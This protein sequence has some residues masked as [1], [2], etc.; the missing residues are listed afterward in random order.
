MDGENESAADD[1]LA[2]E[3]GQVC[4]RD[5]QV[6][7]TPRQQNKRHPMI[8]VEL[9]LMMPRK[10]DYRLGIQWDPASNDYEDLRKK[11]AALATVCYRTIRLMK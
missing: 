5:T 4:S 8:K 11:L 10:K 9:R 1:S 2:E 7:L 6:M 3:G